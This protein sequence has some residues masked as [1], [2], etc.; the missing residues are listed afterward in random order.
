ME[1]TSKSQQGFLFVHHPKLA[2]A[3]ADSMKKKHKS[4]KILPEK[5]MDRI[6]KN[7]EKNG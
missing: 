7:R 4:I 2:K 5:V 6:K 1:F 3:V